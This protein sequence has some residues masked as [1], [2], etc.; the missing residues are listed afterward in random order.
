MIIQALEK[1]V[2]AQ[3]DL[4]ESFES[5]RKECLTSL[6]A[7]YGASLE[8]HQRKILMGCIDAIQQSQSVLLSCLQKEVSEKECINTLLGILDSQELVKMIKEV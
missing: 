7:T 2:E 6:E 5:F 3:K 8:Q 1:I 4:T